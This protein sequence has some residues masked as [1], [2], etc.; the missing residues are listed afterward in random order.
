V[1]AVIGANTTIQY[2]FTN[3]LNLSSVGVYTIRTIVDDSTDSFHQNDTAVLTLHN[4]P[5][6]NAYPYLQNFETGDGGFYAEG[7]NSSWEY[8]TPASP[9]IS[10]A[11]SGTKV[12]KTRLSGNHND[13]ERSYLYAP[14]FNL[15]GLVKPTL[16]FSVALDLE[17]CGATFCDGVSIEYSV[18]GVTW[19]RLDTAGGVQSTNWYNKNYRVW[20]VENYTRWHTV[21]CAL[22]DS[23]DQIRFR[24]AMFSDEAVNNEGIAIDDIHVYDNTK[25]IY[26]GVTMSAPVTNTVSGNN[27][28][29]FETGGK[30]VASI[31]PNNQNLGATDVQAFINAGAVRYTSSQY[32]HNR[33]LVIKPATITLTDSVSVR[34]YFLDAETEALIGATGCS[35]CAKPASAY[36]LGVS[37]YSDAD[38]AFENGTISDNNQG[39]W[40]FTVP[41]NAVKIPFDKGY[42]VE[43]K[44]KDFS[45]FW[46]NNGGFNRSTPLPVQ[47]TNF[48]VQKLS[49]G[50]VSIKWTTENEVAILRYE[51]EL[52]NSNADLSANRF[53]KIGEVG[54]KGNAASVQD[55]EY[56]DDAPGKSGVRYY[57]LKIIEQDGS[58]SYSAVRSVVFTDALTWKIFPNPSEGVFHFTCQAPRSEDIEAVVLDAKGSIVQ[59]YKTTGTGFLQK[60]TIN[61]ADKIFANGMYLLQVNAGGKRASFK[62]YKQ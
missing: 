5:L 22:P 30:L 29:D 25:G 16:S 39:T 20:S 11:A 12:W 46:L 17:D 19:T 27:W 7:I 49:N 1:V 9:K 21:S 42:Y 43:F 26:D 37:K 36:E 61:L 15:S 56:L 60:I 52:A 3:T 33:N 59:R 55:Y 10:K 2:V 4:A 24:F 23:L 41:E 6:I 14:C 38:D 8:G 50:D 47:L 58:A 53:I 57:R 54:S 34:F 13:E 32:Y 35:A 40:S 18:D 62:L 48:S 44:T 45:E 31:H 28:V 51:I